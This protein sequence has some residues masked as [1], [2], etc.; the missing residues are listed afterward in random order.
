[1]YLQICKPFPHRVCTR[2]GSQGPHC[3]T[4]CSHRLSK[5]FVP[6]SMAALHYSRHTPHRQGITRLPA[7]PAGPLPP[8]PTT[9]KDLT[10]ILRGR[11][12]TSGSRGAQGA[13]M[14]SGRLEQWGVG[15]VGVWRVRD[16]GSAGCGGGIGEKGG[17]FRPDGAATSLPFGIPGP[18]IPHVPTPNPP[19]SRSL[20]PHPQSHVR[21]DRVRPELF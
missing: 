7:F 10:G 5:S 2:H 17:R 16:W 12:C 1:M 18:T 15:G 4:H 8:Q 6:R 14:G 20:I 9:H 3:H 19:I 13:G 21:P 11:D